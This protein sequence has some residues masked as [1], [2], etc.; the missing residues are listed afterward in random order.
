VGT[1]TA[2][3]RVLE[4]RDP[5]STGHSTRVAA[6]AERVA[7]GLGFDDDELETL[8]LGAGLHDIGKL[9]VTQR[10]LLEP[11]AL[12]ADELAEIRAHPKHG[13]ALIQWLATVRRAVPIVLHHHE[14]WDG[15]GYPAGL[16]GEEIPLAAR[17]LAAADTF[18]AMTSDRPYRAAVRPAEAIAELI[19]CS[20]TQF[21]PRVVDAFVDAWDRGQ[22]APSRRRPPPA[23]GS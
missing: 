7:R 3:A 8:R 13:V 12:D 4:S 6:L 15:G 22:L 18:D 23:A 9:A 20:G 19:R 21:D 2:L 1:L 11:G 10:V 16:A 5:S 17:I 14:R